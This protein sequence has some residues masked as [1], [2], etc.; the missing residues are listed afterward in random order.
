MFARKK[1]RILMIQSMWNRTY[2]FLISQTQLT[3]SEEIAKENAIDSVHLQ[4]QQPGCSRDTNEKE[5]DTDKSVFILN[6]HCMYHMFDFL[7]LLS[8]CQLAH[9]NKKFNEL[10]KSY[11]QLKYDV[12]FDKIFDFKSHKGHISVEVAMA[13]FGIFAD[14]IEELIMWRTLFDHKFDDYRSMQQIFD[15]LQQH[16]NKITKFTLHGFGTDGLNCKMFEGLEMLTLDKC[17]ISRKWRKM[18]NLK[19]LQLSE[20]VFR[21]WP[22]S[23][24]REYGAP[25]RPIAMP[26]DCLGR[27]DTLRLTDINFGNDVVELFLRQNQTIRVL[28]V[29]KCFETSPNFFRVLS[30]LKNL[31]EFEFKKQMKA[32]IGYSYHGLH[33]LEKL[34]ILKLSFNDL[35][36]PGFF[37]GFVTN[38]RTIE[39]FEMRGGKINDEIISKAAKLQTL[40]ILKLYEVANLNESHIL[41]IAGELKQLEELHF[42]LGSAHVSQDTLKGVVMAANQLT[43]LKIMAPG[44][45]TLDVDTFQEI[46]VTLKMR[47]GNTT[48]KLTIYGD[49]KQSALVPEEMLKGENEQWLMI[50][51]LDN[52]TNR[53]YDDL[54]S[55]VGAAPKR[56]VQCYSS[57]DSDYYYDSDD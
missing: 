18:K 43:C 12:H 26:T 13:F 56:P 45:F 20:V 33:H 49:A 7:D 1:E 29:V 2:F 32:G 31:E 55:K 17:S 3:M 48:L 34:K 38:N 11:I 30:Q 25:I 44:R 19:T 24:Y 16:C 37:E 51:V 8:L 14:D 10:V 27:L 23:T 35:P 6:D 21:R 57:D 54:I 46:L 36:T 40:K 5:G 28:S 50:E 41:R 15:S 22:L 52:T 4:S 47:Q 39:H 42:E 9:V 53:L